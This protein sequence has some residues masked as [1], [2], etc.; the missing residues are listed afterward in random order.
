MSFTP[1]YV[2]DR[3]SGELSAQLLSSVVSP[4]T[5]TLSNVS[6]L[7]SQS[8]NATAGQNVIV[9]IEDEQILCSAMSISGGLVTLTIST[10]GYNGTTAA[11][12]AAATTVEL[13][14]VTKHLTNVQDW[15]D[16]LDT[17]LVA[18]LRSLEVTPTVTNAT[19]LSVAGS[20]QTAVFTAGRV[21]LIQISA[22]WYR[23][24]VR[25]SSFSTNTTINIS[26][27]GFPSSGTITAIAAELS[28]SVKKP[29]DASLIKAMS[30]VPTANPPAGYVWLYAKAKQLWMMDEDGL[31]RPLGWITA[32]VSSSSGALALDWSVANAY[33]I[34]LTENITSVVHSNGVIG[35]PLVLFIKQ[36]ASAAKTTDFTGQ[37]TIFGDDITAY[38]VSTSTSDTDVLGFRVSPFDTSDYL[39]ISAAKGFPG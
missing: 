16:A 15:A 2:L 23:A 20:D 7:G 22:T 5:F 34:T 25:S 30:A 29:I 18:G 26:G 19:T 36:H 9:T 12:H 37:N 10:R 27:D 32:S 13:H 35:E 6:A 31:K 14:V 21:L 17:D 4:S 33:Y 24:V 28:V 39:L 11:T 8:W 38:A 3:A 1:F